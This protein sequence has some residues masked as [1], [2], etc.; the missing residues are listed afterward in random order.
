MIKIVFITL[1]RANPLE[2]LFGAVLLMIR[3]LVAT[4]FAGAGFL[5]LEQ[6][7]SWFVIPNFEMA[8]WLQFSVLVMELIGAFVTNCG[9]FNSFCGH[10]F[11]IHNAGGNLGSEVWSWSRIFWSDEL[12]NQSVNHGL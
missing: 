7:F 8:G 12:P 5:K 9:A 4:I 1:A 3:L 10:I 6:P 2:G 11:I